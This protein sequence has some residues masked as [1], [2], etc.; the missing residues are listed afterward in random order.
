MITN[1]KHDIW[2]ERYRPTK[3]EDLILP[4]NTRAIFDKFLKE[5]SIPHLL[6]SG[7][8]GT[9]KTTIAKILVNSLDCQSIELNASDE[10]GIEVVRGKI[11]QFAMMSA[12]GKLK[13]VLLDEADG[14]T[15]E[16]QDSLKR[17]MEIYSSQTR[18]ILTCNSINRIIPAIQSRCQIVEFQELDNKS[19]LKLLKSILDSEKTKYS[20]DDLMILIDEYSPR[21]RNMIQNLQ[22]NS[23]N[24]MY[25]YVKIGGEFEELL[26]FIKAGQLSSIRKLDLE[27][28]E[29]Y[30]FLFDRVNTDLTKDY[31]K[32]IAISLDLAEY[33]YRDGWI[34]DKEINFA[35]CC[36]KIMESLGVKIK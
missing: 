8:V 23:I 6:L 16:S 14:C 26:Q 1:P 17:I 20:V 5:K 29:A 9:G 3:L 11:K 35:A 12:L 21:I 25:K 10:R 31:E 22:L 32:S 36:I 28:T 13:V 33:L 4:E 30:K 27:Y 15:P 18:F 7:K 2:V 34:A 24:G 19:V